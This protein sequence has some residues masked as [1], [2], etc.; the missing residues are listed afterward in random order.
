VPHTLITIPFSHF[1]EKARWALDATGV[2]YREEGHPPGLH[3]RAVKRVRGR[4]SVPVLVLEGGRVLDDSPLIVRF[5]DEAAPASWKILPPSSVTSTSTSRRT[6]GGSSISTS[7]RGATSRSPSSGATCPP[8][9]PA[10]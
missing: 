3:R 4:G 2:G 6:S 5:A 7:C 9:R 1:C 8:A 10:S